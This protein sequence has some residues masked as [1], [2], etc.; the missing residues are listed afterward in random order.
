VPKWPSTYPGSTVRSGKR[1][2]LL[3]MGREVGSKIV[4]GRAD[5]SGNERK[6]KPSDRLFDALEKVV[7]GSIRA[8]TPSPSHDKEE[9]KGR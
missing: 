3:R 4:A 5:P 7:A 8:S 9:L 1:V 6:G 2:L